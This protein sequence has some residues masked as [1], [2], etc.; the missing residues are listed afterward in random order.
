MKNVKKLLS[1][2]I[3]FGCCIGTLVCVAG[4]ETSHKKIDKD[5]LEKHT[6]ARNSEPS[7]TGESEQNMAT[8]SPS[9]SYQEVLCLNP[10]EEAALWIKNYEKIHGEGTASQVILDLEKIKGENSAMESL[11]EYI[12]DVKNFEKSN[13]ITETQLRSWLS[14]EISYSPCYKENGIRFSKEEIS[15]IYEN[16]NIGAVG[17]FVKKRGIATGR[18]DMRTVPCSEIVLK[19]P[20]NMP[21]DRIQETEIIVGMPLWVLHES[22]DNEFYYVQS[23]YYRGWVKKSDVAVTDNE[24]LWNYF[25][26]PDNF[27]VVADPIV[28]FDEKNIDMGV[29]LPIEG[30]EQKVFKITLPERT[31]NGELAKKSA[32]IDKTKAHKGFI[33]YTMANY[34][35]QAFKYIGTI[36]GWGGMNNGVDCSSFVCAVMRSFGFEMPRNTSQ[37]SKIM[38]EPVDLKALSLKERE[39]LFVELDSPAALFNPGHVRLVLGEK[40]GKYYVIHAPSAG[41]LVCVAEFTP[42]DENLTYLSI[43][44]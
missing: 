9:E 38:C 23:Y 21:Y 19:A 44:K 31:A 37:Q 15:E 14:A 39:D 29:V 3:I 7:E 40:D 13:D 5:H 34:Y 6:E 4:C 33:P 18:A 10:S 17:T 27:A 25:V 36:Y 43:I 12:V 42:I 28:K 2:T 32:T 24:E 16:R 22:L 11:A 26:R 8:E 30:E 1:L 20:D 35:T 41:K